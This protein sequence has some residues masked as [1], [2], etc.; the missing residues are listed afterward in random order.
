MTPQQQTLG[1][2]RE[3]AEA[4]D[5]MLEAALDGDWDSVLATEQGCRAR[6]AALRELG[7]VAL[8]ADAARQKFALIQ[9]LLDCDASIR[10]LAGPWM[11]RLQDLLGDAS[12]AQRATA[13]YKAA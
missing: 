12:R 6:L 9:R 5:L 8:D 1:H 4:Y 13:A 7:E 10:A 3:L 2:Y 11:G